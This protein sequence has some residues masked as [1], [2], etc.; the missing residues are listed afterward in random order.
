M[1]I[2]IFSSEG[3]LNIFEISI[4]YLHI[5]INIRINKEEIKKLHIR[6]NK[7]ITYKKK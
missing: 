3:N 6:R 2:D 4:F 1:K 5:K 7:E